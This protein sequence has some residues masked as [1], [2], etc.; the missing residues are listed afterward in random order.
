MSLDSFYR[1][2]NRVVALLIGIVA[3]LVVIGVAVYAKW[4]A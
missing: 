3:L 2:M 1:G 4:F